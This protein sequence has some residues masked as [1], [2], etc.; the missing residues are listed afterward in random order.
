MATKRD[1]PGFSIRRVGWS[2][3]ADDLRAVRRAV[4][5]EE[6]AIS[7]DLEWDDFDAAC[8]HA[9]AI[10]DR[11]SPVGCGRLLP[12]GY[13]GRLAVLS[14]W[15]G[16][17]VGS[18]LLR[19]LMSLARTSGHTRVL[20]NAQTRA[21]PFYARHGFAAEGD[22]FFEAGIAHQTMARSLD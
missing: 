8:P 12:N 15:R 4:F 22:E 11:Q 5:I 19:E 17:G 1:A 10:D 18:A 6:Q 21:M 20:L 13:I 14:A 2:D 16:Q 3:A 9:L 7:E